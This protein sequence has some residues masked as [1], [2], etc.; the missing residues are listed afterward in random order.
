MARVYEKV[1]RILW[2]FPRKDLVG[3]LVNV[4]YIYLLGCYFQKRKETQ[5]MI[6][7]T[8]CCLNTLILYEPYLSFNKGGGYFKQVLLMNYPEPDF[9]HVYEQVTVNP[10]A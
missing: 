9:C 10:E 4:L 8:T 5:P 1:Y 7:C 3:L 2:S 6:C